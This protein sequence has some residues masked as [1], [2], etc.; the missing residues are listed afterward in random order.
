M[1]KHLLVFDPIP[2]YRIRLKAALRAA[3]YDIVSVDRIAYAPPDLIILNASGVD[4]SNMMGRLRKALG[5]GH[6]PVVVP[7]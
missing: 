3:Q 4:L 6:A 1:P 5:A 7:G 2:T